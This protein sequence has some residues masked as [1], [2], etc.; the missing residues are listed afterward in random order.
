M[1]KEKTRMTGWKCSDYQVEGIEPKD[2]MERSI[3][4]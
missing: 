3:G 2:N 1:Y 4:I